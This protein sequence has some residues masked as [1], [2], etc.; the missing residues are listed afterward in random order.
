[1]GKRIGFGDYIREAFNAR[2]F[3]LL[4]PPNWIALGV[5]ALLGIKVDPGFLVLGAGLELGYLF[6]L[7]NNSRFQRLI[8]GKALLEEE[9]QELA[10]TATKVKTLSPESKRR[11]ELLRA[12]CD[13]VLAHYQGGKRGDGVLLATHAESLNRFV[14][15]F[16]QLLLTREGILNLAREGKLSRETQSRLEGQARDLE[17]QLK[18][19]DLRPELQRSL[20]GKLAIVRQRIDNLSEGEKKLE[21]VESELSRIEQQVELLREQTVLSRDSDALTT[22]IDVV[23][24]SLGDTAEWIKTQRSLFAATEDLADQPPVLLSRA[25]QTLEE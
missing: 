11:F 5:F 10:R 12:K 17:R 2:P 4:I 1:M 14:W 22:Q 24:A 16:L 8:T 20:E 25:R 9:R 13:S 6:A 7:A 19:D 3:G 21:Y 15:I 18:G 23:G